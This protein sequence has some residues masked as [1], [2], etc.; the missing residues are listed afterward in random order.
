MR[1]SRS[2]QKA[3][4]AEAL[5]AIDEASRRLILAVAFRDYAKSGKIDLALKTK[6]YLVAT[7]P[8]KR[9]PA[10]ARKR[11]KLLTMYP[12]KK[13]KF[14]PTPKVRRKEKPE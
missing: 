6:G 9:K 5:D 14:L 10:M 7:S 11:G 4:V 8:S 1:K 13:F 3:L 2:V 12:G